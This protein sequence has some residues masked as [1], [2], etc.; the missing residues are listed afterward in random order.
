MKPRKTIINLVPLF[1][2]VPLFSGFDQNGFGRRRRRRLSTGFARKWKPIMRLQLSHFHLRGRLRLNFRRRNRRL[3]Q[4]K[5]QKKSLFGPQTHFPDV[6]K[7]FHFSAPFSR[8]LKPQQ[9]GRQLQQLQ[10]HVLH[11]SRWLRSIGKHHHRRMCK[12]THEKCNFFLSL[13]SCWASW[14]TNSFFCPFSSVRK[15]IWGMVC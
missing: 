5:E 10:D 15:K 9:R 2:F 13:I 14:I 8:L 12:N 6:G 7:S 3:S 1:H 11:L 4:E